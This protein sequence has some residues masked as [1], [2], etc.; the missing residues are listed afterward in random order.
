LT[1]NGRVGHDP[2][3]QKTCWTFGQFMLHFPS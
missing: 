1:T 2:A 3:L